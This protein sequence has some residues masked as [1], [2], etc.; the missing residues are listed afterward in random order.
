MKGQETDLIQELL[1]SVEVLGVDTTT[2]V[3]RVARSNALTLE[4]K[5]IEFVMKMVSTHYTKSIDEIINSHSKS[6]KRIYALKFA[7]YYLYDVFKF[8]FGDLKIFFKRDKSLLSRSAQEIRDLQDKD[9]LNT[10]KKKFDILVSEFKIKN[11][12]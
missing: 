10:T 9:S 1:K 11:N 8:S 7:I 5:R 2:H 12:V 6:Q 4:D 3:L